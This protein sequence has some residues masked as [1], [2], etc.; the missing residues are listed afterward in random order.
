M[1]TVSYTHPD[2]VN[3]QVS[4][5]SVKRIAEMFTSFQ[6]PPLSAN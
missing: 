4:L 1:E 6:L 3:Y 2:E 5:T